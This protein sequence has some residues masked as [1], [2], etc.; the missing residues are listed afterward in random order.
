M[1]RRSRLEFVERLTFAYSLGLIRLARAGQPRGHD[2]MCPCP[3]RT[4][5]LVVKPGRRAL[6]ACGAAAVAVSLS[7][8]APT[9]SR[10]AP[11]QPTTDA[12]FTTL[13]DGSLSGGPASFDKWVMAGP[14]SFV[15]YGDGQGFMT[16][17]GLGM[18]WYPK[19]FGDAVFRIDYRDV[20]T[21]TTGYSNGGIMVGFPAEQ[22]C[23][24]L[25]PVTPACAHHVPY[26][27]RPTNWT[28][29]WQGLPGPF[30]PAQAYANDPSLGDPQ[31]GLGNAC[32]RTSTART[33]EAWV[34]VYCGNEI[35]VNDSPD[36]P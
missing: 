13:L 9:P 30:P 18:L 8:M 1:A 5:L 3:R 27:E 28:Y 7:L 22:I 23:T 29:N 34:A 11:P 6:R 31:S 24:P 10:A 4:N 32:G 14:G 25:Y 19:D 33:N 35:Q 20:R 16:T 2:G 15:P 21:A 26:T 36:M 12:G 17:G